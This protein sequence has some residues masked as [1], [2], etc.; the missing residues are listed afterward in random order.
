MC[1][2]VAVAV[3]GQPLAA[4]GSTPFQKAHLHC[5]PSHLVGQGVR[6]GLPVLP[7]RF[8]DENKVQVQIQVQVLF[9]MSVLF[10]DELIQLDFVRKA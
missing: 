9:V 7:S 10:K 6:T 3:A 1:V 2:Q 5:P 4:K 8:H